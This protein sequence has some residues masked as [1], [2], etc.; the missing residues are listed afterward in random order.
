MSL[1]ANH[2]I[3]KDHGNSFHGVSSD[4][5]LL[6]VT[7]PTVGLVNLNL[8]CSIPPCCPPCFYSGTPFILTLCDILQGCFCDKHVFIFD[9]Y[10]VGATVKTCSCF[11]WKRPYYYKWLANKHR[12]MAVT[13][14]FSVSINVS[15][16]GCR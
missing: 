12:T 15:T 5:V 16:A 4:W 6:R 3:C 14:A 10:L 2:C 11:R 8:P 13:S 1:H 9:A 7:Q